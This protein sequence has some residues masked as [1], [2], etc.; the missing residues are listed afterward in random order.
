M[1]GRETVGDLVDDL[2]TK[3]RCCGDGYVRYDMF[4]YA[5]RIEAAWKNE[6]AEVVRQIHELRD[7]MKSGKMA[8]GES[9]E[10]SLHKIEIALTGKAKRGQQA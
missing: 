5:R 6:K 1:T 2:L 7:A 10:V 8:G 3:A 9:C 4:R